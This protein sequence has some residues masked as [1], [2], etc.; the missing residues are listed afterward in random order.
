MVASKLPP[1]AGL[2]CSSKPF[3]GS[4]SSRVQSA[5]SP[6]SNAEAVRGAMERP[7]PV[8]PNKKISGLYASASRANTC[9]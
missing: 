2:V 9:G 6:V 7:N 4:I 3:R 8:A 5:V 1:K